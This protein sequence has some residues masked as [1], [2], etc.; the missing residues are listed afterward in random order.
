MCGENERTVSVVDTRG[1]QESGEE[2]LIVCGENERTVS[3]VDT[4]GS[5]ESGFNFEFCLNFEILL[6]L[7]LS[8]RNLLL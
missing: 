8:P 5:Q 4:R 6:N 1:S 2:T 7:N 3:V